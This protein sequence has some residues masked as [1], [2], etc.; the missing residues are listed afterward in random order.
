M[1]PASALIKEPCP[2]GFNRNICRSAFARSFEVQSTTSVSGFSVGFRV[3]VGINS[4]VA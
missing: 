4:K 2:N 3:V 1:A